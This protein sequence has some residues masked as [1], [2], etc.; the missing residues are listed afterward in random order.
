MDTYNT[1]GNEPSGSVKVTKFVDQLNNC[2]FLKNNSAV[3]IWLNWNSGCLQLRI[4][5]NR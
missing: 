4:I 5:S 1:Y 3:W 2:Q